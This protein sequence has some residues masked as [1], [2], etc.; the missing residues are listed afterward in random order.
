M[1]VILPCRSSC[2]YILGFSSVEKVQ[3]DSLN[4]IAFCSQSDKQP[5]NCI[6]TIFLRFFIKWLNSQI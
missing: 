6:R 1:K 3:F 4:A 5:T 2:D